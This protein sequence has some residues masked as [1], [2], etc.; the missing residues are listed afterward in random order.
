[1][2]SGTQA[3]AS[4]SFPLEDKLPF[5]PDC[6]HKSFQCA[7]RMA[8]Q[9]IGLFL[10]PTCRPSCPI[11]QGLSAQE[12]LARRSW[13]RWLV[14]A[15]C[16]R[17]GSELLTRAREAFSQTA[18]GNVHF[19]N[20]NKPHQTSSKADTVIWSS[21]RK[22]LLGEG[23]WKP[24]EAC[25]M[26]P[27]CHPGRQEQFHTKQQ[28]QPHQAPGRCLVRA[29]A[30]IHAGSFLHLELPQDILEHIHNLD[31]PHSECSPGPGISKTTAVWLPVL[32]KFIEIERKQLEI[33]IDSCHC[34]DNSYCITQKYNWSAKD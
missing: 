14:Q 21:P 27:S 11:A 29:N 28:A 9:G 19:V 31:E 13:G 16:S 15:I 22:F 2:R 4:Q 26:R 17:W 5:P 7:R 10:L 1:M 6:H 8:E 30:V 25:R 12:L 32:N 18:T 24:R 3:E 23:T 20:L 34:C 33:F